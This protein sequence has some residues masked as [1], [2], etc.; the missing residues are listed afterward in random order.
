MPYRMFLDDER[1]PAMKDAD[2]QIV[3]TYD[4][5]V[6]V[7]EARGCPD[8]ISFDHDLGEESLEGIDVATW[9]VNRDLD[10]KG[11]FI[12][13]GFTFY[14]HSQNPVGKQNIEGIL[15]SYLRFRAQQ[16]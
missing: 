11:A 3:R 10:S 6:E 9:M 13:H 2:M 8:Y 12:P 7:M 1:Y 15:G 5:A 4:Q 16:K 14:V